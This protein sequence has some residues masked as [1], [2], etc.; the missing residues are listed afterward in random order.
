MKALKIIGLIVLSLVV[1]VAVLSFTMPTEFKL[2]RTTEI[3]APQE[4]VKQELIHFKNS[5][6]WSPWA[7]LDTNQITRVEGKDGTVGATF[8]WEGNEDVGKGMQEIVSISEDSLEFKVTFIEPFENVA[9]SY[10]VLNEAGD[11]TNVTWGFDSEMPRPYNVMSLFMN[12]E[13]AIGKDY[14]KGLSNLKEILE[15][16][17]MEVEAPKYD[18]EKVDF[19]EKTYLTVRKR[20]GFNEMNAFFEENYKA[21]YETLGS[22]E[23]VN[24]TGPT[25]AIYY[26]WDEENQM[27]D[28]AAAV[29]FTSEQSNSEFEGFT[30][31]KLSGEALKILYIGDYAQLAEPHNAIHAYMEEKLEM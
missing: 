22:N 13:E 29:P 16:K 18:I 8:Y 4:L 1:I 30:T 7:K 11:K 25:S 5:E 27:T 10:F 23:S 15:A 19:E 26:D 31:V 20:I 24:I 3:N 14:E 9:N 17:A 12:M 21:L 28:V 6:N 2:E